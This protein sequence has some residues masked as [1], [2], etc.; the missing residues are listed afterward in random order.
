MRY[1]NNPVTIA[2]TK[3]DPM[4]S[5][6]EDYKQSLENMQASTQSMLIEHANDFSGT[7][8]INSIENDARKPFPNPRSSSM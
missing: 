2:P 6:F 5:A 3:Q 7:S 8:K 1:S 4:L